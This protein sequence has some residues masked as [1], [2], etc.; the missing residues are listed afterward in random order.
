MTF[1]ETLE[2]LSSVG[3]ISV[4]LTPILG[5]RRRM[6]PKGRKM[7]LREVGEVSEE[8]VKG[9]VR[10]HMIRYVRIVDTVQKRL[11]ER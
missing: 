2:A 10:S 1:G 7:E 4:K 5:Y 3:T 11:T 8:S 6:H 9:D